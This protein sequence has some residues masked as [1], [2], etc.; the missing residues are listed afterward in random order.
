[1]IEPFYFSDT[2]HVI[3][4]EGKENVIEYI[5]PIS[6]TDGKKIFKLDGFDRASGIAKAWCKF[7]STG[8]ILDSMNISSVTNIATGDWSISLPSG[9]FADSNYVISIGGVVNTSANVAATATRTQST[10]AAR[11]MTF[12]VNSASFENFDETHVIFFGA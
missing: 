8:V 12:N 10:S 1:V 7:N 4:D 2:S 6:T 9:L 3:T 5:D 11:I